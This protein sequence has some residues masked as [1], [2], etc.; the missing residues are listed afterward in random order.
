MSELPSA[1]EYFD[2]EV[3]TDDAEAR[4][5]RVA[6]QRR[7]ARGALR[8]WRP[9]AAVL[10]LLAS[11]ALTGV[12]YFGQHRSDL[13]ADVTAAAAVSAAS[14]GSAAILSY[15]PDSVDPDLAEARSYLTGE[16][17]TYYSDF[18]DQIVAPAAKQKQVHAMAS[19][20]RAG[21]VDVDADHAKVMIFLNQSTT[22][23]DNPEPVQTASSVMVGMTKVD[24]RWLISSFE[25]I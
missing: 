4:G 16:F 11:A 13:D 23:R 5:S 14:E 17:L 12:L 8:H 2:V 15:A 18:A 19:V 3:A 6:P 1:A 7:G 9:M 20:V 22:S 10:A 24:D 25:P 21:P